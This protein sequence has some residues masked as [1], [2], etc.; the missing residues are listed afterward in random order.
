MIFG[1][2]SDIVE[3]D[4]L[5]MQRLLDISRFLYSGGWQVCDGQTTMMDKIHQTR[6][7]YVHMTHVTF[8]AVIE[9]WQILVFEG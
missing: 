5:T 6:D 8:P 4:F 3:N 7:S 1:E 2:H 9:P